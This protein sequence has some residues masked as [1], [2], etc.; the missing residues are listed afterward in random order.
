MAPNPT[1]PTQAGF[2]WFIRNVM[3]IGQAQLPDSGGTIP[4][5]Y[6]NAINQV[7][8]IINL[9]DPQSYTNAVYN[10]AADYLIN[11]TPDQNGQT[12]F[13][14]LRTDFNINA[15]QAGVVANAGDDSTSASIEVVEGL[16]NLTLLDLQNLK[17]PYGRHYLGIAQ[18]FGTAWGIS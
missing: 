14:D 18:Q 11:F 15:F 4:Y 2:L 9:V 12:F 10:L 1:I 5:A 13:K 16:K 3:N 6:N 17:T 7:L 8:R